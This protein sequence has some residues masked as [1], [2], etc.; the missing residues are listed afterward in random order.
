MRALLFHDNSDSYFESDDPEKDVGEAF[1]GGEEL[2]DVSGIEH[3]EAAY[4][5]QQKRQGTWNPLTDRTLQKARTD[6]Q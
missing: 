3:H 1:S 2:V 6:G 5:R 4:R